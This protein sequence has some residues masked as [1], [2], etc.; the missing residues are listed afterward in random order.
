MEEGYR[1]KGFGLELYL[2]VQLVQGG[3]EGLW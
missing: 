2:L 1:G 3:L